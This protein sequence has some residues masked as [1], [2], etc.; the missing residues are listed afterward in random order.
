MGDSVVASDEVSYVTGSILLVAG[1][2]KPR[3]APQSQ[4]LISCCDGRQ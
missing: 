1:Q 4:H 2:F 3:P